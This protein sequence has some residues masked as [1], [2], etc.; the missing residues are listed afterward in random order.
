[1]ASKKKLRNKAICK[2][3]KDDL[4]DSSDLLAE[5]VDPPRFYCKACG[6]VAN[7][8]DNLCKAATL[9]SARKKE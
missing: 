9:Q 4:K 6:R 5:L 1:M 3:S 2:W 8:S 7:S